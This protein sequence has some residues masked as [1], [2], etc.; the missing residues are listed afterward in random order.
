MAYQKIIVGIGVLLGLLL[1]RRT[2]PTFLKAILIGLAI[3]F[4]LT[5]FTEKL[6]VNISFFSFGILTLGFSIHQGIHKKWRNFI[7]GLF[8]F[9][10]FL[11][12][13]SHWPLIGELRFLMIIPIALYV[14]TLVKK[15][16]TENGLS[17]ITILAWYEL[18]E[19]LILMEQW[20]QLA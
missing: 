15:R 2:K 10:S 13:L 19:F 16:E 7:I 12:S 14:W 11:W 18:S 17:I 6:L 1:L 20:A 8:A 3:S 4:G 9:L 5:F